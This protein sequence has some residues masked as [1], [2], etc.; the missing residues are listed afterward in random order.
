M[1]AEVLA[2]VDG[3]EQRHAAIDERLKALRKQISARRTHA[4][5]NAE[6]HGAPTGRRHASVTKTSHPLHG[7]GRH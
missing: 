1:I 2:S 3:E 5:C 4:C 6:I 7:V